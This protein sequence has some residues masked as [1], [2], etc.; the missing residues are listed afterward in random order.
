MS[1]TRYAGQCA[2]CGKQ[3]PA[4]KGDFQSK[5]SLPKKTRAKLAAMRHPGMWLIRCFRCK[6]AGNNLFIFRN[7]AELDQDKK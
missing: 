4:G 6:G 3:T 7:Q 5:G 1:V 2:F